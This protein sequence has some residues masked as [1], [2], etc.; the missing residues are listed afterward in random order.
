MVSGGS[1]L[2]GLLFTGISI[3]EETNTRRISNLI[4]LTEG[5]RDLWKVYIEE[6]RLERILSPDVDLR[7]NPI[8]AL[9]ERFVLLLILHLNATYQAMQDRQVPQPEGVRRDV[10]W[11]FSLPIPG[12]VWK[13]YKGLQDSDLVQYVDDCLRSN[14][15]AAGV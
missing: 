8:V 2:A 3:R 7:V 10:R 14:E 5:H 15:S 1:A 12:A 9:E 13:Q 6:P 11:L 4:R